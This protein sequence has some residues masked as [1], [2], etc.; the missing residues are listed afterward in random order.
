MVVVMNIYKLIEINRN[1][2]WRKPTSVGLLKE[3]QNFSI[4]F[5]ELHAGF[6]IVDN[7]EALNERARARVSHAV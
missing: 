5:L 4:L 6:S 7:T 3:P 2:A 1:V